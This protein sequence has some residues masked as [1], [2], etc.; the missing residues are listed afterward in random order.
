MRDGN[1]GCLL[2]A[3]IRVSQWTCGVDCFPAKKPMVAH[4]CVENICDAAFWATFGVSGNVIHIF[5]NAFFNIFNKE[6]GR[7]G[8][9]PAR[10]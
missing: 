6:L 7:D 9:A 4:G 1:C 10:G 2:D 8:V 3:N 5:F